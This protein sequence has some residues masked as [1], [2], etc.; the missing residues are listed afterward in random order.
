MKDRLLY[1]TIN[2]ILVGLKDR[3]LDSTIN[4]ISDSSKDRNS[5]RI[6]D[7]VSPYTISEVSIDEYVV[8]RFWS[9]LKEVQKHTKRLENIITSI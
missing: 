9:I 5:G 8:N 7:F 3:L 2:G 6:T 1:F 4:G